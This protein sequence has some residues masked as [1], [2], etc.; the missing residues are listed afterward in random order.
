MDLPWQEVWSLFRETDRKFQETDRKFQET[1]RK[2]QET[3]RKFQETER[4]MQQRSEEMDQRFQ[5]TDRKFQETDRKFQETD[6]K[7]KEVSVAI[8]RL[9]GR[10]GEFVEYAVQPAA[11]RL[12]REKGIDVHEVHRQVSVQ[13]DEGALEIDL[14]VINQENLVGIECKSSLSVDDVKEHLYRLRKVKTLMPAYAN[15]RVLGAVAGMVVPDN[16]AKFAEKNGLYVM[17]QSGDTVKILNDESF[18][19]ASW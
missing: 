15:K 11:V 10:L 8:G 3:D 13:R 5:E 6:K 19:P 2:F 18:N 14:M 12:F 16:V 4:L 17:A 7:I 1:D 9:G